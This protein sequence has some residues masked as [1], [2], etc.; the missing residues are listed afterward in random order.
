MNKK[1]KEMISTWKSMAP[2]V[3][4]QQVIETILGQGWTSSG[5]HWMFV[6]EVYPLIDDAELKF[7]VDTILLDKASKIAFDAEAL[8]ISGR[9]IYAC[10]KLSLPRARE[11][12]LKLVEK[13]GDPVMF[14][15]PLY[16]SWLNQAIKELPIANTESFLVKQLDAIPSTWFDYV[17]NPQNAQD[18]NFHK[19]WAFVSAHGALKLINANLATFYGEKLGLVG[20]GSSKGW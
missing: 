6:M 7:R 14:K 16:L 20:S 2:D 5:S 17:S 3:L 19:Y 15:Y 9:A 18:S 8:E 12:I 4:R 1:I 13:V 11:V 10:A